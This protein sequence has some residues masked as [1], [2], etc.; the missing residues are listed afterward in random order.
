MASCRS[1][2]SG[3]R[4][5]NATVCDTGTNY[6][7]RCTVQGC[8]VHGAGAGCEVLGAWCWCSVH[9]LHQPGTLHPDL[10]TL[11][12]ALC[13][14]PEIKIGAVPF[15]TIVGHERVLALLRRAVRQHRLPPA[16]LFAGPRG[17]GKRR[18]S[19]ALAQALNCTD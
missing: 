12:A 1:A 5:S 16:L 6:L 15:R 19:V 9:P 11:H 3:S 8:W 18:V 14:L 7:N 13:T 10:W 4:S 17:V 2:Y